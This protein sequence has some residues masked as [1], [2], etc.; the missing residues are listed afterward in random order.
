MDTSFEDI[1]CLKQFN[2]LNKLWVILD[3]KI[4]GNKSAAGKISKLMPAW[5]M[6]FRKHKKYGY[7]VYQAK[8]ACMFRHVQGL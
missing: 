2:V 1:K 7:S 3:P 5:S 6:N 8:D 4:C